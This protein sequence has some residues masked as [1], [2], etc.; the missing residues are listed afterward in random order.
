MTTARQFLP[1]VRAASWR[2]TARAK[3]DEPG[4]P[5]TVAALCT[6]IVGE[7]LLPGG[8]TGWA[9]QG[10]A[11][12]VR[13]DDG[14]GNL[15]ATAVDGDLERR[16]ESGL[17]ALDE[18]ARCDTGTSFARGSRHAQVRALFRLESGQGALGPREAAAFLGTFVALAADAWLD[19]AAAPGTAA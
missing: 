14:C 19:A 1:T 6:C 4:E 8:G 2:A 7:G 18:I 13:R 3:R 16:L 12:L 15:A 10:V 11:D 9:P 5:S 17:A